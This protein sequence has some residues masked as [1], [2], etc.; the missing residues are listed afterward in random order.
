VAKCALERAF[1]NKEI[2]IRKP[3]SCHLFPIRVGNF[4]G[5][6]L[7]YEKIKECAP[8]VDEGQSQNILLLETLRDALTRA[9]GKE[10]YGRLIDHIGRLHEIHSGG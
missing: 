2:S 1:L 10:W 6:Y 5:K 4:G 9:Y 7:Y 8:G 3:L